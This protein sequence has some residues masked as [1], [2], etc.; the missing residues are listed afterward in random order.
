LEAPKPRMPG[1]RVLIVDDHAVVRSGLAASLST[2]HDLDI[3]GEAASGDEAFVRCEALRPD[4]V[5]MDLIMPATDGVAV[6]RLIREEF[7]QI[8]IIVLTS[9]E[10]DHLVEAALRA[11]AFG[12]IMKTV[13]ADEL[14][15]AI[16]LAHEEQTRP[17]AD[18]VEEAVVQE[19][20]RQDPPALTAR[21]REI[22]ALM[23]KGQGNA[24]IATRL[25]ISVSA[26]K[27]HVHNILDKLGVESRAAAVATALQNNLA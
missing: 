9:F 16:R 4:V 2:M 6:T 23:V 3:V 10:Q 14:T 7:P 5:L 27:Y 22:L 13:T 15:A 21:Q 24:E 17:V 20:A 12:Y 25:D 18:S 19:T 8:Q 11:G 26:V 1:I